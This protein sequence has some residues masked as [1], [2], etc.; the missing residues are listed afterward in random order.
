MSPG[1]GS[2]TRS[3]VSSSIGGKAARK[4]PTGP[5]RRKTK[6][7]IAS[8]N[9]GPTPFNHVGTPLG[10]GAIVLATGGASR[11][12]TWCS[13]IGLPLHIEHPHPP[14]LGK[15]TL[16]SVEHETAFVLEGELQ[17]RAFTL[18]EHDVVRPVETVEVAA[19]AVRA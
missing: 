19:R 17:D 4:T 8:R 9:S 1:W 16:V 11:V 3:I 14:Q 6:T 5:V 13:D 15:L 12:I 2:V 18:R 10:T 7:R